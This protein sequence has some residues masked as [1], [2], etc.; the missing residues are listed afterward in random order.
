MCNAVAISSQEVQ[1][2]FFN[3]VHQTNCARSLVSWNLWRCTEIIHQHFATCLRFE[4]SAAAAATVWK[5]PAKLGGLCASIPFS[6]LPGVVMPSQYVIPSRRWLLIVTKKCCIYIHAWTSGCTKVKWKTIYV[7]WRL[8]KVL[9][10][11]K[12]EQR[13]V[14]TVSICWWPI[15]GSVLLCLGW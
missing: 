2:Q 1:M 5:M 6:K 15:G 14:I 4:E 3:K 10:Y 8:I 11:N 7:K 12:E 9:K 13:D